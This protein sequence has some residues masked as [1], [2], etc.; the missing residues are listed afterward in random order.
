MIKFLRFIFFILL[1]P[2]QFLI[3]QHKGF[4]IPDTLKTKT[5]DYVIDRLDENEDDEI[6]DS[7]YANAF[8]YKA[9]RAG[10]LDNLIRAYNVM[11]HKSPK[12]SWLRYCDSM[13]SVAARSKQDKLIGTAYLTRG[14]VYNSLKQQT[15]A[16]DD[17]LL[18][19]K[20]IAK[21]EDLYLRHKAK[22]SIALVKY[23]LGYYHEAIALLRECEAYFKINEPGLPHLR[24]LHALSLCYI[25][26]KEYALVTNMI[27]I[28]YRESIDMEELKTIPYFK[29]AEGRNEFF[30]E[31]YVVAIEKLQQSLPQIIKFED[32]ITVSSTY[33]FIGRS[34][35]AL[36]EKE[37][38]VPFFKKVDE[39]FRQE[40][41]IKDEVLEAYDLL[42]QYYEDK[43]NTAEQLKYLTGLLKAETFVSKNFR[44][45]S[46]N[47]HREYDLKKIKDSTEELKRHLFFRDKL[48]LIFGIIFLLVCIVLGFIICKQYQRRKLRR[49]KFKGVISHKDRTALPIVS[50][51]KIVDGDQIIKPEI[52]EAVSKKL[53]KFE[54]GDAFLDQDFNLNKMAAIVDC[55]TRYTSRIICETRK[56]KY[57]EY[58]DDLRIDY[59]VNRLKTDSKYR[60]YT[61]KAL[62]EEAGFKSPQKF[63]EA[64]KKNTELNPVYFIRELK[65]QS[66]TKN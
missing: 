20:F 16:L 11:M 35:W 29:N 33:Y 5:V 48:D 19:D 9:K 2:A 36:G 42:A 41:F 51:D 59:I 62:T 25:K 18:A 60:N 65:K 17:Y 53:E 56:K 6:L 13:L 15:K 8:L 50:K 40:K 47:M 27:D 12:E 61:I 14:I 44:Y 31:N 30:K 46:E 4:K 55:N 23:N 52:I 10:N 45:L 64:F 7:L 1:L 24:T 26:T 54:E 28:G 32:F 63:K 34:Y 49:Q 21:T 38:A 58:I 57:I 39:L 3:A 43:G 22:F 37:K 66:Q